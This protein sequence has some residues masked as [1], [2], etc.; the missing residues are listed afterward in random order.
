MHTGLTK[1]TFNQKHLKVQTRHVLLN[2]IIN[3]VYLE[4][5]WEDHIN[6]EK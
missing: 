2:K 3:I 1:N 5:I 6:L 4:R